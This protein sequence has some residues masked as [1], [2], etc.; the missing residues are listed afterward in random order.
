MDFYGFQFAATSSSR[1]SVRMPF[2]PAVWWFVT[3]STTSLRSPRS[4]GSLTIGEG[5]EGM[6]KEA[7]FEGMER[8]SVLDWESVWGF[9]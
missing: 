6:E 8:E 1:S 5:I 3:G 9:R 2:R 7:V 4:K